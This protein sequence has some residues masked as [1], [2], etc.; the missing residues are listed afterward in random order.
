M[1]LDMNSPVFLLQP[2]S[3][4]RH[5]IMDAKACCEFAG[6]AAEDCAAA[7]AGGVCARSRGEDAPHEE[8]EG[9]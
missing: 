8:G 2:V 6:G 3:L 5:A 4:A 7:A 9:G 1:N